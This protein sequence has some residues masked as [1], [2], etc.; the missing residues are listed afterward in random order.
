MNVN[1]KI[2]HAIVMAQVASDAGKG[3]HDLANLVSRPE[4]AMAKGYGAKDAYIIE[5]LELIARNPKSG[6]HYYVVEDKEHVAKFLVY[7]GFKVKGTKFQVSFHS[8]NDGLVPW[9][10]RSQQTRWDRR[11]SRRAALRLAEAYRLVP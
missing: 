3:I 11:G 7:F 6:Y 1:K 2:A 4:Y 8:F 10:K 5:A 9:L